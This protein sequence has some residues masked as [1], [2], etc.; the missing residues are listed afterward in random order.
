VPDA[1]TA[2]RG[3]WG[4]WGEGDERGALNLLSPEKVLEAAKLI[5]TG[6]TYQL[7]L[8]IQRTGV[9]NVEYRGTP[10][11]LTLA[12]YRDE[13]LF[14]D[15]FGAPPETG[16][17]ED[18]L[19]FASHTTTHM[20]ALCHV[21]HD[22]TIYNGHSREGMAPYTGAEHCGIE[23]AGAF[24]TR[25]VLIDVAAHKGVDCLPVA[26]IS[27]EDVQDTLDAQGTELRAG[28]VAI[29]RTGWVEHFYATGMHMTLEQPGPGIEAMVWL[30]DHDVVAIGA[31][32][33]SVETT[34][35]DHDVFL[36]GHIE[37]LVNRGIHLIEHLQLRDLSRDRCYEFFFC[38]NPLLITG[39]TGCPINPL[40]I[41]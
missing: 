21:H 8:P 12:N 36:G 24:A 22:G 16:A 18:V 30:A 14:G 39:A 15:T 3:N 13:K 28:D 27:P 33:S 29:I 11:R 2:P 5:R 19:V 25:G 35:F 6:K 31:D 23:K 41:A 9:P 38:A 1:E 40:A 32:N 34:P 7:A 37:M 26:P 17:N 4:R 10:Q 20:D